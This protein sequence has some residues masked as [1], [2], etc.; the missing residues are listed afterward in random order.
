M[1][2]IQINDRRSKVPI[3]SSNPKRIVYPSFLS[4]SAKPPMFLN[5]VKVS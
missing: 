4:D 5:P 2:V 3:A 1:L